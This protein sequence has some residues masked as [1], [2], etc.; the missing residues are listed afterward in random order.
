MSETRVGGY[1]HEESYLAFYF[2]K[3]LFNKYA[4]SMTL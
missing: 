1:K 2:L 4:I 3:I